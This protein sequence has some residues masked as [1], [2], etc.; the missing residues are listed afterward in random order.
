MSP[1]CFFP[2][3]SVE[4]SL[5]PLLLLLF[6]LFFPHYWFVF[7]GRWESVDITASIVPGPQ[8]PVSDGV[9][10]RPVD[11]LHIAVAHN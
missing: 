7:S 8:S 4:I 11:V 5:F 1:V 2:V 3:K 10:G 6:W 9:G